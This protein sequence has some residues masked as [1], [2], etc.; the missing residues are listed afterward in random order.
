MN[1]NRKM[2][3]P[4]WKKPSLKMLYLKCIQLTE[5]EILWMAH[6]RINFEEVFLSCTF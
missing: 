6:L 1:A 3:D 5:F 2:K 4:D